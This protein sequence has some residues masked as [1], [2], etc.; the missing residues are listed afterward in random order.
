MNDKRKYKRVYTQFEVKYAI[1]N[2]ATSKDISQGGMCIITNDPLEKG[3]ELTLLFSIPES[4]APRIKT[5]G[6]VAWSKR[7][8]TG[9]YEAGI[10][11]WD[12]DKAFVELIQ[13]FIEKNDKDRGPL[14]GQVK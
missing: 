7:L 4:Q 8:D 11:F 2:K 12:M 14:S 5:F 10:E 6:K 13:K 3:A 9:K 1:I